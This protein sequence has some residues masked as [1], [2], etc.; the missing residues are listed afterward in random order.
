MEVTNMKL[1][2]NYITSISK[3]SFN[4]G[5]YFDGY[6]TRTVLLDGEAVRMTITHSLHPEE[7]EIALSMTKTEFLNHLCELHIEGWKLKYIDPDILDGTQWDLEICFSD[8]HKP[9]KIAGSNAYPDNFAD[10]EKLF[11]IEK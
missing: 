1:T 10:V 11:G 9:V 7:R 8:G 5:G 6:E 3:I 2:S 4:I